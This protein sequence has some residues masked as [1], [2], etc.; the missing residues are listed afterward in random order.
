MQTTIRI[1]CLFAVVFLFHPVLFASEFHPWSE[2]IFQHVEEEYGPQAEKRLRYLH[3]LVQKNQ[4]FPVLDKLQLINDTM[5]HLP[6]IADENHWKQVDYW[7]A[8]LETIATFGGDCEDIAVAKWVVL[9]HLGV[10]SQNLRLAYVKIKQ[11]G[12]NHMVLLYVAPPSLPQENRH[13]LVL[14]NYIDDIKKDSE[15]TDLLAVYVTDAEGNLTLIADNGNERSI[16]GV[17]EK[18]KMKKL[19]E[20]KQKIQNNRRKYEELNEGRPLLPPE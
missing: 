20:L 6:W 15:R 13:A 3:D 18:R 8:P 9:N 14:D 19:E 7:A 10:S 12:E 1:V 16:K 17:Y 2:K 5:N 4:H 11:T